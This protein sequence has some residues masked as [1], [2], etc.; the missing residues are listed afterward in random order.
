MQ[1]QLLQGQVVIILAR[2]LRKI[3]RVIGQDGGLLRRVIRFAF[4]TQDQR[5]DFEQAGFRR[6]RAD[7]VGRHGAQK[8]QKEEVWEHEFHRMKF[9]L[10]HHF[11]DIEHRR[12][13]GERILG[14]FF[15]GACVKGHCRLQ[16]VVRHV[17][18]A[19][20]FKH[21]DFGIVHHATHARTEPGQEV[22]VHVDR[23]LAR[24]A[25]IEQRRVGVVAIGIA[26]GRQ[27]VQL[28]MRF[29]GVVAFLEGLHRQFPVCR[30]YSAE[31]PVHFQL[32]NVAGIE[33]VCHRPQ[34]LAQAGGVVVEVDKCA[35]C[36]EIDAARDEVDFRL[37]E[38]FGAEHL[39]A[40]N[41]RVFTLGVPAPAVERTNKSCGLAI[42]WSRGKAHAA[43]AAGIVEG[44][45]AVPGVDDDDRFVEDGVLDII[46]KLRDFLQAAGHLPHVRP[47]FFIFQ[48]EKGGVIIAFG[49]D[50]FGI[51][52]PERNFVQSGIC[53]V[54]HCMPHHFCF[55]PARL[56]G[57]NCRPLCCSGRR[58]R[59]T[60]RE[61]Y[62]GHS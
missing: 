2:D 3:G 61:S 59:N 21:G 54:S 30:Q 17:H 52:D 47:D 58:G 57:R 33:P 53:V 20:A 19:Q 28:R 10:L 16:R 27:A 41:E 34:A 46:A 25:A 32:V 26:Q 40:E 60:P 24:Q 44:L 56:Q 38:Q 1:A 55:V 11:G 6:Q 48:R 50:Q 22:D 15:V 35:T 62:P 13:A 45:Y 37:V 31:P 4:G 43:V 36:P 49:R 5:P 8:G 51:G 7:T 9:D 39:L 42:A 18:V 23:L 14:H 12:A 29:H